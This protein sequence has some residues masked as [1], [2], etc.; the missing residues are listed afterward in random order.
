MD[1]KR[2]GKKHILYCMCTVDVYNNSLETQDSQKRTRDGK[3]Q[4]VHRR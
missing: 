1:E 3:G 4:T 2:R